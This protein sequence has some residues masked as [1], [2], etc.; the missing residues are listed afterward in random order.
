MPVR[1]D[2]SSADFGQR[3]KQF[4]AAKR[5]V[6]A[7]VERATRAIVD[8]VAA[9]G[10]AALLEA[11][12]KFDRLDIDAAGLRVT[13]AEIEAARQGLRRRHPRCPEIRPRPDRIVP[14]AAIAEGR[15]LYGCAG[16]RARLALERGRCGRALR[17]RRHRGLSVLGADEC[18]AGQRCRRAAGRHGGAVAGRQAQPAGAGCGTVSAACPRSIAS[19]ARRRW[20]RWPTARRRSRRWRKS[21]APAMPMSPPPSGRCS[22]RSAST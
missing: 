20:R 19:A 2:T 8:D 18:G 3:F 22:A 15:A 11:T 21:S 9:R 4:L 7:D 13:A 10:D 5:E 12:K 14:P 17:A 16:R 1:L 6:S